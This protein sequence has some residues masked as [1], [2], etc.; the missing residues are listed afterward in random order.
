MAHLIVN[1]GGKL[2]G[3]IKNQSAKNSALAILC[4]CLMIKGKCILRDVPM[5]EEINRMIE[6]LISIGVKVEKKGKRKYL[7]D[8]SKQLRIQDMDKKASRAMRSSLLLFGALAK[9][10]EEYRLYKTGGCR[11]GARTVRPHIYALKKLG[12]EIRSRSKYYEIVNKKLSGNNIVMYE[13]GDTATENAVMVAVL[14]KGK[15][16]IKM[17]SANYMVQDLCYFLERA[18][19]KIQGI[20][21]TTLIIN[22]VN[23]LRPVKDYYIMPDPIVAMTLIS[24]AITTGSRLTIKECPMDF[25]ELEL[26]KLEKMGLRYD[27]IN[28]RK[29]KNKKFLLTDI[30]VKPSKLKSLPDKIYG[31]PFPGLNVDN[32]PL[33]IP[34]LLKANGRTLVHDWAYEN[35]S[36]YYIDLQKMGANITMLDSHRVWVEGPVKF[37]PAE[38]KCPPALR[39][40]VIILICMLATPGKSVLHNTYAIDRGYENLYEL[41]NSAGADILVN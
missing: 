1:G 17:A 13:S 23:K 21:T 5:I 31:R 30:V 29:S 6:L 34:I 28:I 8:A 15:T 37:K 4:A 18:G 11:L 38:L 9:R 10:T 26:C 3:E 22:G 25:L 7:I 32:L 16:V 35:R 24:T 2:K 33:F 39:V 12:V 19:A 41:L 14:A 27:I 20:G 40:A 36:V